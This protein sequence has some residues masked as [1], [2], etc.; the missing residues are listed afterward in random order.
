MKM[1]W[2]LLILT[3]LI[4]VNSLRAE[5]E[6]PDIELHLE[7]LPMADSQKNIIT[8]SPKKAIKKDLPA[9]EA[10][11]AMPISKSNVF[12][13]ILAKNPHQ[14]AQTPIVKMTPLAKNKI[15]TPAAATHVREQQD[16]VNAS[17]LTLSYEKT[18]VSIS[19]VNKFKLDQLVVQL[20]LDERKSI[21]IV[22]YAYDQNEQELNLSDSQALQ[23][24]MAIRKYLLAQGISA[25]K[26]NSSN[27]SL[28]NNADKVDIVVIEGV[29]GAVK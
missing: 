21:Q 17:L 22:G 23:R 4:S 7:N 15:V 1:K 26:I 19:D 10:I 27:K 6:L 18:E 24:V 25:S 13:A 9:Q 20:A 29:L 16:G 5:S 28:S 12:E 11:A 8:K 3:L 2:R 14:L